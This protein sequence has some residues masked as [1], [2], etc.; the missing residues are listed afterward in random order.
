MRNLRFLQYGDTLAV[1]SPLSDETV[2]LN[3]PA[4][5]ILE[6]CDGTRNVNDIVDELGASVGR[7]SKVIAGD[8]AAAIEQLLT[9]GLLR[10]AAQTVPADF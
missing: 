7:D 9:I 8:V 4:A 5:S 1:Y 10:A 2:S 6:L 3:S